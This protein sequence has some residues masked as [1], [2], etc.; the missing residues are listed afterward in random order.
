MSYRPVL[1]I[2]L[3]LVG[4]HSPTD[5]WESGYELKQIHCRDRNAQMSA[6]LDLHRDLIAMGFQVGSDPSMVSLRPDYERFQ[7]QNLIPYIETGTDNPLEFALLVNS[8]EP[9]I[10]VWCIVRSRT[11][12]GEKEEQRK[13]ADCKARL[14][15]KLPWLSE[16]KL[17]EG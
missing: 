9:Q 15:A 1:A 14:F 7:G 13:Y 8:D 12:A 17:K 6:F 4:C 5:K 3:L 10:A 11:K 16:Q 2:A